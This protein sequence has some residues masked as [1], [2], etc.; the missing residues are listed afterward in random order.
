MATN[1]GVLNE[2]T[3]GWRMMVIV[4][5]PHDNFIEKKCEDVSA[6]GREKEVS[7]DRHKKQKL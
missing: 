7:N 1:V 3:K 2:M 4:V 5:I 6:R